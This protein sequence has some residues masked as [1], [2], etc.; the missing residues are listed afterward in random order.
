MK[1]KIWTRGLMGMP[2]GLALG[3]AIT[4]VISLVH[5]DGTYYAVVPELARDCGGELNAVVLQALLCMVYG[6]VWSGAT[7]VWERD[8]WSLLRQS[9]IHFLIGSLATLPIAY[10]ARW[11]DRSVWGVLAYFGI[12]VA[13]YAVIW[14]SQYSALKRRVSRMNDKLKQK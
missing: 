13:V 14:L 5:N 3:T 4:I 12:F 10:Y 2:L 1:K 11:M 7:V 9:V 8:D 6:A